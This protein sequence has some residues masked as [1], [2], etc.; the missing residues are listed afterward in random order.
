MENVVQHTVPCAYTHNTVIVH[1]FVVYFF[2][3]V[4][5]IAFGAYSASKVVGENGGACCEQSTGA[6]F[7][8]FGYFTD[9]SQ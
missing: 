2:D 6:V 1:T 7:C 8:L 3:V 5:E 4:K 9:N